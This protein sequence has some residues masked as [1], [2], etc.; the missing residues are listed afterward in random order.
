VFPSSA[1]KSSGCRRSHCLVA[2]VAPRPVLF[3]N[4][5]E[6]TWA[7]P[8]GQFQVLQAADRLPLSRRGG[9]EPRKCRDWKLVNSNVG[10]FIRAASTP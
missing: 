6:D 7:N 1:N 8:D 3:T 5:T 2:L 10:Y 4:A 9:L